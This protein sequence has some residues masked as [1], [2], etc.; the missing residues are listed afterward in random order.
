MLVRY[1]DDFV[2]MCDT[3]AACEQAEERVREVILER[4]GLGAAPGEDEAG[5]PLRREAGL[6][7]PRLSPAQAYERTNLGAGQAS[8]LYF[9]Q[10]WP[11]QRAMQRIRQR[12]KELTAERPMPRGLP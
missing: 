9:L 12:V 3:K 10:R 1:A 11:S 6:R 7:L 4:L 2:V 5:R 8:A